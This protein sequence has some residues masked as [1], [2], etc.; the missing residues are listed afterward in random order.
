MAEI[1]TGTDD[2]A[3]ADG[4]VGRTIALRYEKASFLALMENVPSYIYFG[5]S[6]NSV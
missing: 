5:S 1:R 6:G 4:N 3:I 2:A